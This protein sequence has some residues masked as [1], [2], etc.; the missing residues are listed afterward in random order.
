MNKN[1]YLMLL[2]KESDYMY[3]CVTLILKEEEESKLKDTKFYMSHLRWERL[4]THSWC[5]TS[6]CPIYLERNIYN[7]WN[8]NWELD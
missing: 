7:K 5:N 8:Y 3:L 2:R 6:F 1:A 4:V